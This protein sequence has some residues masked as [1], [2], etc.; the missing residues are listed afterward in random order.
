MSADGS[1]DKL[2]IPYALGQVLPYPTNPSSVADGGIDDV[3]GIVER[4]GYEKGEGWSATADVAVDAQ[5]EI[6]ERS[7]QLRLTF[8]IVDRWRTRQV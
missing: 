2:L 4:C 5:G 8:A 6:L 3:A 1:L 7:E